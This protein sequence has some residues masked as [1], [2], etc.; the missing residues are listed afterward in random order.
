[1]TRRQTAL[2]L[3]L[4]ALWGSPYALI[5]VAVGEIPPASLASARLAIGATALAPLALRRRAYSD[6]RPVLPLVVGFA[7]IEFAGAFLLIA[8][9]ETRI[10]S[11]LTG[12]LVA[13]LPLVVAVLTL[14]DPATHTTGRRLAGLLGGMAGVALLL[15]IDLPGGRGALLG[16]GMVLLASV[17][18]A[19]GALLLER[20]LARRHPEGLISLAMAIASLALLPA[21]AA[22]GPDSLPS[23]G[24][25]IAVVVLGLGPTG[26]AFL[27]VAHL[28]AQIGPGRTSV[29]AYLAPAFAVAFG[30]FFLGESVRPATL[31]GLALILAGSHLATR[32]P[33][34]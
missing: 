4:A 30:A 33:P 34:G 3:A 10:A 24:A 5:K 26:L 27:L 17:C 9:G 15:G 19:I 1:M 23:A 25:V 18:Y 32:A 8:A 22:A 11:S 13:S 28:I 6:L 12:I 29:V 21:A 20:R 16:A 31:A 14:A 7:L 2:F